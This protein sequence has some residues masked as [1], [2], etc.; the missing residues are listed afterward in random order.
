MR[1]KLEPLLSVSE[2][3]YATMHTFFDFNR[4][5]QI[6]KRVLLKGLHLA[7]TDEFLTDHVWVGNANAFT[8]FTKGQR[9]YFQATVSRYKKGKDGERCYDYGFRRIANR[10]ISDSYLE[11]KESATTSE[12]IVLEKVVGDFADFAAT[13]H[14]VRLLKV[15]GVAKLSVMIK[16]VSYDGV[17]VLRSSLV[18]MSTHC[19]HLKLGDTIHFSAKV[20]RLGNATEDE[21]KEYA[22]KIFKRIRLA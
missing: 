16:D 22:L 1:D 9:I 18:K 3:F 13:V 6:Q 19:T 11:K 15:N 20:F 5:D 10:H 12:A 14:G 17:I 21:D 4:G 2:V 7:E 8:R